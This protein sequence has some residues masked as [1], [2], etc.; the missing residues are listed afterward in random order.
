MSDAVYIYRLRMRALER[1]AGIGRVFA[2]TTRYARA[3]TRK[4]TTFSDVISTGQLP[5]LAT[6][7]YSHT[8]C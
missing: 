3:L 6:M 7:G 4:R 8:S 1:A 5:K 2:R